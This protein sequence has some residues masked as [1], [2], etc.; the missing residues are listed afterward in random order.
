[1]L[2]REAMRVGARFD[3]LPEPYR[4]LFA[5]VLTAAVKVVHAQRTRGP[6]RRRRA[7]SHQR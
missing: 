4:G 6:A 1:M 7:R 5:V 2:S 3:A